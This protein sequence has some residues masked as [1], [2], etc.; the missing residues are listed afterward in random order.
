M[1]LDRPKS[2]FVE[3]RPA[4]TGHDRPRLAVTFTNQLLLFALFFFQVLGGNTTLREKLLQRS[5]QVRKIFR[6]LDKDHTG[7]I[8]KNAFREALIDHFNLIGP[9]AENLDPMIEDMDANKDGA[10]CVGDLFCHFL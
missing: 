5:Y 1:P 2:S 6:I 4:A 8:A 9:D 3:P 7:R 10:S